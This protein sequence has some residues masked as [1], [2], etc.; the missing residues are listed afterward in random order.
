MD[1]IPTT[2]ARALAQPPTSARWHPRF[3]LAGAWLSLACAAHCIAL[4]LLLSASLYLPLKESLLWHGVATATGG[5]LLAA[6]HIGNRRALR[7]R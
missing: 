5:V 6:A 4:P 3:D 1:H 2:P 7:T